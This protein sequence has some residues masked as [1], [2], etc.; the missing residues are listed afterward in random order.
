ML[1]WSSPHLPFG[2]RSRNGFT[3]IELLVTFM[4]IATLGAIAVPTYNYYI[5]KARNNQALVD[6]IDI[7]SKI[8]A[9]QVEN[10]V[11]LNTLAQVGM[12]N[13]LDPWGN[14][15]R[16]LRILGVPPNLIRSIWRKDRF[17]VPINSDYDLYS[18]GKDGRTNPA[19]TARV[20]RDDIIRA[21]NGGYKGPAEGF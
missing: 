6:I 15:Y 2:H 21:N 7:E 1:Y 10:Q 4:I 16:Y 18:M 3:L 5:D 9:F 20:S 17:L 14:P 8:I 11:P 13:R 19:L 12:G